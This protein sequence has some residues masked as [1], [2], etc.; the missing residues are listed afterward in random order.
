MRR[1]RGGSVDHQHRHRQVPPDRIH[2]AA[3]PQS[4]ST[5]GAPSVG[6]DQPTSIL[7][8]RPVAAEALIYDHHNVQPVD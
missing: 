8:G 6:A 1:R 5:C 4:E 3:A 2:A 7:T